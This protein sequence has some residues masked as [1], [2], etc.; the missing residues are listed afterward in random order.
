MNERTIVFNDKK[1]WQKNT[2]ANSVFAICFSILTTILTSETGSRAFTECYF[3]LEE[4]FDIR[5]FQLVRKPC[6]L[7]LGLS[8]L[9]KS[10]GYSANICLATSAYWENTACWAHKLWDNSLQL[11]CDIEAFVV[12]S[13]II[14]LCFVLKH[15]TII[16]Y[17]SFKFF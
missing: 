1:G 14:C 12:P 6:I 13:S 7:P 10:L 15:C 17:L 9:S 4:V 3:Q 8:L 11:L 5:W 16:M 2:T